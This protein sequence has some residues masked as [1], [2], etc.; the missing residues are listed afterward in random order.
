MIFPYCQYLPL[1]ILL[2]SIRIANNISIFLPYNF[3]KV[4]LCVLKS[5]LSFLFCNCIL[6]LPHSLILIPQCFVTC[7][8]KTY[9]CF[10][11]RAQTKQLF[12]NVNIFCYLIDSLALKFRTSFVKCLYIFYREAMMLLSYVMLMQFQSNFCFCTLL[13]RFSQTLTW[14]KHE[15]DNTKNK[16]SSLVQVYYITYFFG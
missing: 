3:N 5:V 7:K 15:F 11:I 10:S 6:M 2:Y 13:F 12:Y 16:L 8:S 1:Y 4:V 14:L 9:Y